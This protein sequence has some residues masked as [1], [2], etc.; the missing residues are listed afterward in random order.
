MLPDPESREQPRNLGLV[1]PEDSPVAATD[2]EVTHSSV[3]TVTHI[4][5]STS[6]NPSWSEQKLKLV[7]QFELQFPSVFLVA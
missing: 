4:W 5:R 6:A 2:R 1:L 3:Q 7:F